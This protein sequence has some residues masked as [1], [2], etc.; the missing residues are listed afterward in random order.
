VYVECPAPN[1]PATPSAA[2]ADGSPTLEV[3][4]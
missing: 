1:R 4:K 3:L 2:G